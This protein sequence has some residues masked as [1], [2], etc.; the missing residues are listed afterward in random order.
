MLM[1]RLFRLCG[2]QNIK[3]TGEIDKVLLSLKLKK[4][5]CVKIRSLARLLKI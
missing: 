3:K 1:M 2:F 4:I 5:Y